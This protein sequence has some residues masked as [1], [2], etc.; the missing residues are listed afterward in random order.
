MSKSGFH[1]R[2]LGHQR[3]CG[4]ICAMPMPCN[5]LARAEGEGAAVADGHAER[6]GAAVA[7]WDTAHGKLPAVLGG[8]VGS[9]HRLA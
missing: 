9:D 3:A 8:M 5:V 1:C 2:R 7:P 4:F 6:F